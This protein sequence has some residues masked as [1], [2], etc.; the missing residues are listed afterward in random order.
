MAEF[1]G[2]KGTWIRTQSIVKCN[3]QLIAF[4]ATLTSR[5]DNSRLENENYL[6]SRE[7]IKPELEAC[8][9]EQKYNALLISKAPEMLEMLQKIVLM[10]E[11]CEGD[12][13]DFRE[14]YNIEIEDLI[15]SAT[16]I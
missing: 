2:T 7:R 8:D 16:E 6:D 4:S 5:V 11:T 13:K 3:N 15:K 12:F 1:K 9:L 14:R 10:T